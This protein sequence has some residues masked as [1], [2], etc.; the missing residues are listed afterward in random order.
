MPVGKCHCCFGAEERAQMHG[1]TLATAE[2]SM[3]RM[4]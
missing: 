1:T 4:P 2:L 3:H